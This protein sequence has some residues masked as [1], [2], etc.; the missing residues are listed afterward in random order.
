MFLPI[1]GWDYTVSS[2]SSEFNPV[3]YFV[4]N[5]EWVSFLSINGKIN[6]PIQVVGTG[7][8]D[9]KHWIRVDK[10]PE[11][12]WY[13]GFLPQIFSGYPNRMGS[14]ELLIQSFQKTIPPFLQC[15]VNG[16]C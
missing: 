14:V 5:Y 2:C 13:V 6:V 12:L 15:Q 16:C 3:F 10:Q 11:T 9:G 4:P 8:Y 7:K 1:Q